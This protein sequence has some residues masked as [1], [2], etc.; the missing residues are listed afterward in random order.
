MNIG[1]LTTGVGVVTNFDLTYV[2]QYIYYVAATQL[3]QLQA[4]VLGDGIITDLDGAGLSAFGKLRAQGNITNGYLIPLA[5][6]LI[7][8]KNLRLSFTNSAAQT[9]TIYA[10]SFQNGQ[11]YI[12]CVRQNALANSGIDLNGF[13]AL[14][15]AN[16]GANDF[17]NVEFRDGTIARMLRD[18]L[19]AWLSL[20]QVSN[21]NASDYMIDNIDSYIRNVNFVPVAAQTVYKL[22]YVTDVGAISGNPLGVGQE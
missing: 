22:S 20:T 1:V 10:V 3:T 15:F 19:Q 21:N 17:W 5:N 11:I 12:Q 18:E 6:G 2:P 9:P 13:A 7:K 8:G 14:S 4:N 16:S